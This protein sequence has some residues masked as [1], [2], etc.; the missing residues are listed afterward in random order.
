[1]KIANEE[2]VIKPLSKKKLDIEMVV[3]IFMVYVAVFLWAFDFISWLFFYLIFHFFYM[4]FFMGNHERFHSKKS[5]NWPRPLEAFSEY[6][7][8]AVTP[9]DE[10]YNSIRI[11]HYM[12]H[13][14]HLPGKKPI[15]DILQDP[16]SVY[17]MGGFWRSLFF[18]LFYE[19]A[20][21]LIDIFNRNINKSRWI[22]LVI[23][24]PL[25]ILFIYY[26]GWVK[27]LG[28]FMAV[29]LLS[30]GGWLFFSWFSHTVSY[31]FGY[32]KQLKYAKLILFLMGIL[33]GKYVRD[34]FFRHA[35]HHAWPSVPPDKLHLLDE[36]VMRNSESRPEMIPSAEKI[37]V[38]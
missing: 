29:R 28:V 6:F 32:I 25:Q 21:F 7:A 31:R 15:Q 38:N 5:K 17:E 22:R 18:C 36:A 2:F 35:T 3:L 10:P 14:T 27:Y 1:M 16:H 30:S 4:R 33:N 12:H 26:F 34:G 23:Y 11:K 20:Q 19:E 24:L 9:W 8:L 37:V 13:S